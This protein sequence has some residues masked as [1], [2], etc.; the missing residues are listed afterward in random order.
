MATQVIPTV[1]LSDSKTKESI[2]ASVVSSMNSREEK[3]TDGSKFISTV[4]HA[5]EIGKNAGETYFVFSDSLKNDKKLKDNLVQ[6]NVKTGEIDEEVVNK[7]INEKIG[8]EDITTTITEK[9]NE[10]ISDGIEEKVDAKIKESINQEKIV[11]DVKNAVSKELQ[12]S[13]GG[14]DTSISQFYLYGNK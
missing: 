9:V 1:V 4:Y 8:N 13:T 3:A 10:A 2:I 5:Y 6:P 7:L 12:G 11:E 14:G